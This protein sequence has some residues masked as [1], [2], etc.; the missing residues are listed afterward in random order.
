MQWRLELARCVMCNVQLCGGKCKR[1]GHFIP[2]LEEKF[3]RRSLRG[4]WTEYVN[5]SS[6]QHFMS[7]ASHHHSQRN[8]RKKGKGMG[9]K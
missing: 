7:P 8:P 4:L 9:N 5:L 1:G 2:N 6:R 3:A